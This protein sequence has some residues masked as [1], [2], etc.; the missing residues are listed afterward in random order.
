MIS[1]LHFLI[2]K[3]DGL[4]IYLRP[5]PI[6]PI[7]KLSNF[8]TK[9]FKDRVSVLNGNIE[10]ILEKTE[11]LI[12]SGP[13]SVIYESVVYGCKLFYLY[14][15]PCDKILENNTSIPKKV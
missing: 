5:H 11:I 2:N 8:D 10:N 14:L 12:T 13:T 7:N 3:D 1:W 9:K 6:L 4:R 15:D